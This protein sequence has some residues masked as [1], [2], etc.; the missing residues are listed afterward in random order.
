MNRPED[1][2]GDGNVGSIGEFGY[3]VRFNEARRVTCQTFQQQPGFN[4]H[5]PQRVGQ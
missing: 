2:A 4:P 3:V 5:S 1:Q